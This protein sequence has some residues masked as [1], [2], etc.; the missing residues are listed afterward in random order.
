MR[1]RDEISL[2]YNTLKTKYKK[3]IESADEQLK[4]ETEM[5]QNVQ[6]TCNNIELEEKSP[7]LSIRMKN[8]NSLQKIWY[9]P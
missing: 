9:H 4:N 2:K 5:P 6:E 3:N 7:V 1:D 8:I